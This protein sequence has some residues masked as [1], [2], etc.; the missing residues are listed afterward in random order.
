MKK[1]IKL[2]MKFT[3]K[4]FFSLLI[5]FV[6]FFTSI[7][8]AAPSG[9]PFDVEP[10]IELPV[11]MIPGGQSATELSNSIV[12]SECQGLFAGGFNPEDNL[13]SSIMGLCLS[14]IIVNLDRLR[15]NECEKILCEYHAAMEGLS[16]IACAKQSAY[17]TCLITGQGF[18]VIEGVLI[19]ALRNNIR[20]ILEDPLAFGISRVQDILQRQV[21]SCIGGVCS[22][23]ASKTASIALAILEIPNVINTIKNLISQFQSITQSFQNQENACSRLD[24][25][26]EELEGILAQYHASQGG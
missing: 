10:L 11:Q 7:F 5:L 12:M 24:E 1:I 15:Q 8:S 3:N 19:G 6:I 25:V 18:D 23:P 13:M 26:K 22:T 2:N 21:E 16:P 17:N 4:L 14:G 9:T 20:Q